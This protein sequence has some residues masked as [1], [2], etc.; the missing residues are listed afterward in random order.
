MFRTITSHLVSWKKTHRTPLLIR[1]A[2]QVGKSFSVE[3]FGKTE[4]DKVI[5]L[6]FDLNPGLIKIFDS[7]DPDSII[8]QIEL[9]FRVRITKNSLLF[10]DEIQEC[11]NAITSLRYFKELRPD[12]FVI[13][14]GSLLEFAFTE[15]IR[16][17]VGRIQFLNMFPLSFY[18]FMKAMGEDNLISYLNTISYSDSI[19]P[20]VHEQ[21]LVLLRTFVILGGMPEVIVSYIETKS[22]LEASYVQDSLIETYKR[23]FSKYAKSSELIHL[24][25]VFSAIPRMVS[26]QI[27]YV[28]IDRESR[29]RELKTA[30]HLL[31]LA[32]VITPV[33]STDASGL[34]L[35]A[36]L[37]NRQK[38]IFLDI[39]LMQHLCGLN[40]EILSQKEMMQINKGNLAEQ[41]I[42]QELL[43][44]EDP[45]ISSELYFWARDK[46]GSSS[47]IDFCI[48]RKGR[49]YPV[50][51][52]SGTT[53]RLR[54]LRI[55]I[56]EKKPPFGIRFWE[57]ELSF[58]DDILSIPLY[59]AGESGRL[60]DE[61][62][63]AEKNHL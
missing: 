48:A 14:A 16:M 2:R 50:E 10:L 23:D 53:G 63:E 51:V 55:F 1:G 33:F 29:S 42:G 41:F 20:A 62:F 11:P 19:P 7:R 13:G 47:E 9:L 26:E 35:R 4:F 37:S 18:E 34:P 8:T 54:S 31:T 60:I 40:A 30:L 5:S 28:N 3:E 43:A 24:Q 39:G 36:K 58:H 52:K 56:E 25:T 12:L 45:Y 49:I 44:L 61:V 15:G 22:I 59:M 32:R 46:Q 17:P 6:N 38:F 27:K 57:G 21:L